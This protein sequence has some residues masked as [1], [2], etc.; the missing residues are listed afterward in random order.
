MQLKKKIYA[1][2]QE[3]KQDLSRKE[4]VIV[5]TNGCFDLLHIGHLHSLKEAA[6]HG[7]IL[8]VGLNSD[9]SVQ[10]LKGIN[11]PIFPEQDRA[12]LL[13]SLSFVDAVLIF[14]GINPVE[15]L[16]IIQPDIFAKGADYDLHELPESKVVSAYGGEIVTLAIVDTI[17]TTA[18][19]NRIKSL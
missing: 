15:E 14:N 8:I 10:R 5:W 2:P 17:S 4:H 6:Q 9:E 18:I 12:H 16:T 1:D 13:S 11:R 3:L 7:D 19:I